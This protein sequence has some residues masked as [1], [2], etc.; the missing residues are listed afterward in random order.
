MRSE[1]LLLGKSPLR[2]K[3]GGDEVFYWFRESA[4]NTNNLTNSKVIVDAACQLSPDVFGKLSIENAI[5]PTC[6][7]YWSK[8]DA[9]LDLDRA[10]NRRGE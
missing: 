4:D 5:S 10:I 1:S 9:F 3:S 6:A 8:M 7:M 2:G